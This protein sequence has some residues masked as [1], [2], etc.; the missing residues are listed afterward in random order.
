MHP[1]FVCRLF[2][3]VQLNE[4]IGGKVDSYGAAG[5][6]GLAYFLALEVGYTDFAGGIGE[7]DGGF[8]ILAADL[9]DAGEVVIACVGEGRK[10]CGGGFEAE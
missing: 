6:V 10:Y 7:R 5:D 9:V 3:N 2:D 1:G 8:G 4:L